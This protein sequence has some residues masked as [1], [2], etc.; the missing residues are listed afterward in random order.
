M[1]RDK[2][3]AHTRSKSAAGAGSECEPI[4]STGKR[5]AEAGT[6][7]TSATAVPAADGIAGFGEN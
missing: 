1:P 6:E 7:T 2:I 5:F 3:A 4:R